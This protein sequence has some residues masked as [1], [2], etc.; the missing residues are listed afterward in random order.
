MYSRMLDKQLEEW[1]AEDV[2]SG[3]LTSEALLP[4]EAVTCG[5]IHA[6]GY[7]ESSAGW[8]WPGGCSR[9]WTPA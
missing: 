1:L 2:G 8:R 3:D 4:A 9:C 5:I 7:G 6:K